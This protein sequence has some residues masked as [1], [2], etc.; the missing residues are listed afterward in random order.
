[1]NTLRILILL[2]IFPFNVHSQNQSNDS[3]YNNIYKQLDTL[4]NNKLRLKVLIESGNYY[5][6]NDVAKSEEF[7]LKANNIVTQN[8]IKNKGKIS[9]QLGNIYKRK[10]DFTKS[11]SYYS[12]AQKKYTIIKDTFNIINT[13]L[14]IGL[15]YRYLNEDIKSLKTYKE[16][17]ILAKKLNSKSLIG[18]TYDLIGCAF[19]KSRKL[20]SSLFYLD[21]ALYIFKNLNDADN[22]NLVNN[23]LSVLYG[24]QKQHKKAIAIRLEIL[25][26]LKKNN[27]KL[28]LSLDYF[29]LAVSYL[30]LKEYDISLTYIDSSMTIAKQ[31]GYKFRIS[32]I[33]RLKSILYSKTNEY[34]QAYKNAI[35]LK[36]YSDS[37]F[38][39]KKQKQINEL[40]LKNEFELERKKLELEK[41]KKE[42]QN[43]FYFVF[44]IIIISSGLLISFFVWKN[45]N[46]HKKITKE[47]LEKDKLKKEIL[48]Q[49]I[50]TSESELKLL[51]ADN[52][53]RLEF[54][55]QLSNQIKEDKKTT[56]SKDVKSYTNNLLIKLQQQ[57]GTENKL[58]SLQEKIN[59]INHGFGKKIITLYPNL[60]KTE[61]EICSFLRLNLSIKEIASIRNA[62]TD[63]IK[64]V[65][66]RIRKKMEIPKNEELEYFIQN[67]N[68]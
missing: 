17:L 25:N 35:L 66:Y 65:R 21:K 33:Y 3:V 53:M 14:D 58:S 27:D 29:N 36:K 24:T 50:K 51:I 39:F 34:E 23:N 16:N 15:V 20:D 13:N 38:N 60:T 1:M 67:L 18:K 4:S 64:A 48:T 63:S 6:K 46:T 49:K 52:T 55:K 47:K 9:H 37:L 2:I 5:L 41:E 12:I 44:I 57:I 28:R 62:T 19:L 30:K 31:E 40:E 8:D 10:G 26:Y 32:K 11:Y 68:L 56:N 7:F 54:V 61:R 42:I 43:E 59:T 45:Y 22:V